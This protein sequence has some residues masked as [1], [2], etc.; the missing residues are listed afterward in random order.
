L[1]AKAYISGCEEFSLSLSL[2]PL[3]SEYVL[4]TNS[5]QVC[6]RR[7]PTTLGL[8]E[9]QEDEDIDASND[10]GGHQGRDQAGQ[11]GTGGGDLVGHGDSAGGGGVQVVLMKDD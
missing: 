4:F 2:S 6:P 1:L 11:G 10:Q 7:I 3:L 8:A 5:A 9:D